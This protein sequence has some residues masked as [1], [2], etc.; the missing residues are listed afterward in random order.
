MV[1]TTA[2]PKA[3]ARPT[4]AR[5]MHRPPPSSSGSPMCRCARAICAWRSVP[6]L[7]SRLYPRSPVEARRAP[8]QVP[9]DAAWP[10]SSA[11]S[12]KIYALR[13][14]AVE[15]IGKGKARAPYEF[16]CKLSIA[17]PV[18][19]PK[20]DSSCSM[21]RHCMAIPPMGTPSAR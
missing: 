17:T 11:K 2:Q 4:D 16:G 3:I 1:D 9:A 21:P 18:T 10:G 13:A 20:G 19:S 8:A 14:P 15:C 5:L 7:W 12:A 6:P